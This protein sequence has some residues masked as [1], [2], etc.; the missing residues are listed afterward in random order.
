[1]LETGQ[2]FLE[3]ENMNAAIEGAYEAGAKEVVVLDGHGAALSII[4]EELDPRA[5]LIRGKRLF[6]YMMS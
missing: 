3:E 1:M 2:T 5:Q 4:L 6:S